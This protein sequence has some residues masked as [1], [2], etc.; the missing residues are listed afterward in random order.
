MYS[1][2]TPGELNIQM[3]NQTWVIDA[4]KKAVSINNEN[5]FHV[6]I[7]PEKLIPIKDSSHYPLIYWEEIIAAYND[8]LVDN[9]FLN[10]LQI[11]IDKFDQLQSSS[12]NGA[13]SFGKNM[14]LKI[15]GEKII[16]LQEAGERFWVGRSGGLLGDKIKVDIS[17]GGWK[18]FEYEVNFSSK[19]APNRNWFRS[20]LFAKQVLRYAAKS[21]TIF[22]KVDSLLSNEEGD[23][24][25]QWHFS[26]LGRDYFLDI[27]FKVGFGRTL[28][29]PIYLVYVGKTGV[30]YAEKKKGRNVNPN[31]SVVTKD[32]KNLRCGNKTGYIV[33]SGLWNRKRC[34]VLNWEEIREFF[35][36][37]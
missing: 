11:A 37:Q 17:S 8:L 28:D 26:H 35:N 12:K 3:T 30:A 16:E 5:C 22:K 29:V 23:L 24:I 27:A 18:T 31:W 6:G 20:D 33:E 2:I 32:G 36:N 15:M 19:H 14:E 21:D 34:V 1:R 13:L 9:Y 25:D 10:V 7:V 4:I